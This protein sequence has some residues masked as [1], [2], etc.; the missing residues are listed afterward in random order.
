VSGHASIRLATNNWLMATIAS[1]GPLTPLQVIGIVHGAHAIQPPTLQY[2]PSREIRLRTLPAVSAFSTYSSVRTSLARAASMLNPPA[3]TPPRNFSSAC[4]LSEPAPSSHCAAGPVCP[5][6]TQSRPGPANC[7]RDTYA[8]FGPQRQELSAIPMCCSLH[9]NC[10]VWSMT[11]GR[12]K[13]S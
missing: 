3:W 4:P 9:V 13:I 1:N 6:A 12:T 2:N 5:T 10:L 7:K 8:S 11:M